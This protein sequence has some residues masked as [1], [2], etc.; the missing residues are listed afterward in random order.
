MQAE[1]FFRKIQI[2]AKIPI[3]EN[4]AFRNAT[5]SEATSKIS[6]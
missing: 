3:K 1:I 2:A 6:T 4:M 5:G